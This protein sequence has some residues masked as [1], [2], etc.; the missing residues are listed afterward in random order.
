[1]SHRINDPRITDVAFGMTKREKPL[2]LV[3]D[4]DPIVRVLSDEIL[5]AADFDVVCLSDGE[6][7]LREFDDIAPDAVLLD[8]E[9]P[10][11]DGFTV[12][13]Q[14]RQRDSGKD[15]PIIMVTAH[16]DAVSVN[17]SYEAGAQDF[18]NKPIPWPVLPHRIRYV[19]DAKRAMIELQHSERRN[20]TLLK[21]IPDQIHIVDHNG[22]M[23]EYLSETP[24]PEFV[25]NTLESFLPTDLAEQ[26]RGYIKKALATGEIQT[27]DQDLG[28]DRGHFETRLVAQGD[29]SVLAIIRDITERKRVEDKVHHLA[30]HD[31]LTGL[32]NRQHFSNKLRR[33]I[34]EAR[35]NNRQL[36]TMYI[37]LD[38][39]KRINDTLGHRVGDALLKA[40]AKRLN[41]CIREADSIA[42]VNPESIDDVRLARLGGDEFVL[43][44]ED[45]RDEEEV[46]RVAA[47]ITTALTTP[48]KYEGHHF[49]V[50]PS[51][52]IA[53][54]PRDG[55][56]IDD[57]LMHADMAMY[58]AKD[59]GRNAHKFYSE[60]MNV[61][62][63]ER[64]DLEN[65]LQKAIQAEQFS[66]HYQPKVDLQTMRVVGVEALL[67]WNHPE[68][69]WISPVQFIPIAE[70][71]GLIIPLGEW[72]VKETCRQIKLWEDSLL[73]SISIAIN[74]SSRQFCHGDLL[75]SVLR[76]VT[77]S[78]IQP[79]MLELEITESM[80]MKDV[81]ETI[82][83]LNAFKAAGIS[84]SVDDFGT[85]YS[86]LSYLKQFPLDALKIDRSFVQDLHRNKDDA[87]ICAAI[88]AMAK[89]LDLRVVAEGIE[90]DE[91]LEFLRDHNCD[92]G[93][94]FL[95]SKPLAPEDLEQIIRASDSQII[96]MTA[97]PLQV[98]ESKVDSR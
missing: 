45:I 30:F 51:I 76:I 50:T 9:M 62:S 57:L 59:S 75:E 33:A 35:A 31:N 86:S 73:S 65:D 16:D 48:F 53:L 52:G 12:C 25:G 71:T 93:Q 46:S 63:L 11:L 17:R 64:L 24:L 97:N 21:A 90:L 77:E 26:A 4:D 29:N 67:R 89:E 19:L 1:M 72:V 79:Q 91:Q 85:G 8:V 3:A 36:A 22:L 39:F 14:L 70:D 84:I 60:T 69:G 47:R 34:K 98:V 49:I 81:D 42:R 58:R 66:I 18:I 44:I 28:G 88:L 96:Y 54:F 15:T 40:V 7:V 6:S 74:V 92:Q 37:D 23:T 95:F 80:L 83:A 27:Y 32:P 13:Q 56:N 82:S 87:A 38:R 5:R 20:R 78:G 41:N 55:T 61:R 94:G 10:G 68:R 2:I 43:L